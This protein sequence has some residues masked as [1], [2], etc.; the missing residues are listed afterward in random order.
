MLKFTTVVTLLA[1][2]LVLGAGSASAQNWNGYNQG[3]QHPIG[4]NG[5]TPS[6]NPYNGYPTPYTN[7]YQQPYLNPGVQMPWGSQGLHGNP[8]FNGGQ[9]NNGSWQRGSGHHR[10]RERHNQGGQGWHR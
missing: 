6:W 9:F 1:G 10:Q 3:N 8:S 5:G 7:P 2:F 4:R